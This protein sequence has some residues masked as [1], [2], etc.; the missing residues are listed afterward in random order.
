MTS[1]ERLAKSFRASSLAS[2]LDDWIRSWSCWAFW[3]SLRTKINGRVFT[4]ETTIDKKLLF[5]WE[6]KTTGPRSIRPCAFY[7]P[8]AVFQPAW[9]HLQAMSVNLMM[10]IGCLLDK[11][12][13]S[14]SWKSKSTKT[15]K[16]L[17]GNRSGS[18]EGKWENVYLVS[19][20]IVYKWQ[21]GICSV[22]PLRKFIQNIHAFSQYSEQ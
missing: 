1:R 9:L 13:V 17:K 14:V 3:A 2:I 19:K 7:I 10:A 8:R 20:I 22:K 21:K 15:V 16:P 18:E 12:H 6:R 5:H 4:E 11:A